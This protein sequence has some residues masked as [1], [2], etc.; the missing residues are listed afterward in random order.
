[1]DGT[2]AIMLSEETSV[3]KYPV[4]AVKMMVRI[5]KVTE[6]NFPATAPF[7]RKTSSFSDTISE[8]ACLAAENLGLSAITPFSQSG[9]TARLISKYR[10]SVPIIALTPTEAVQRSLAL[11]WGVKALLL[12]LMGNSDIMIKAMEKQLRNKRLVRKNDRIIIVAGFPLMKQG[13]T[14]MMKL[15]VVGEE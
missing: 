13:K 6:K 2:D 7:L 14:N 10:P 5:A 11:S 4:K 3:G 1:V 9:F 15:H 12:P 8:A